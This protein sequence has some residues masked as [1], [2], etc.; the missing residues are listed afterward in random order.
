MTG[1]RAS[2]PQVR[3][4]LV[5][6]IIPV[7]NR[8]DLLQDA[9]ASVLAQTYE[10]VEILIVDDG[11]TDE[12]G[13][14]ADR[15]AATH[16]MQIRVIH[17]ANGGPGVAREAARLA[18]RGEFVQYLDSDDLLAPTKFERQVA[19]LRSRR[20]CGVSYG[21]T[22]H[23]ELGSVPSDNPW[24]RTGEEIATMFPSFL[25]SR[26]W[27]T[28]TPLYR[29]SL[30]DRAGPWL[31]LRNEEDWEYDCRLATQGVRLHYCREFV[32]DQRYD[33][34]TALSAKGSTDPAKLRDRA[35]AHTLIYRHARAAGIEPS[36]AEMVHFA[37][38]LFLLARQCGA[39]GLST[40]SQTLFSLSRQASEDHVSRG[41][42]YRLYALLTRVFGWTLIGRLAVASDRLRSLFGRRSR[43]DG[44]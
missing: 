35:R 22:R 34:P 18:A 42:D 25:R 36:A 15:L 44:S 1:D 26:W 8:P 19:G 28:S 6:T 27:G 33:F 14:V 21:M 9:A 2:Q 37:R 20:D 5:T 3:T 24:K 30:L 11:S 41:W 32:S 7:Y 31:R 4:G 29:R 17:Q 12:T 43:L 38:E 13:A 23:Y 16:P 10:P 39:V 40:E